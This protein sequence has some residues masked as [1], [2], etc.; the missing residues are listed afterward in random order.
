[1]AGVVID[2]HRASSGGIE[3][4]DVAVCIVEYTHA[5]EPLSVPACLLVVEHTFRNSVLAAVF[6]QLLAMAGGGD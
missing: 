3:T 2:Y 1:M 5:N 6:F 4:V